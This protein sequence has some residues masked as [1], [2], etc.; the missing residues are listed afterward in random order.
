MNGEDIENATPEYLIAK[1]NEC[2]E[3]ADKE[4]TNLHGGHERRLL[5]HL[6]A[7]FF[8]ATAA[9]KCSETSAEED[10]RR[11]HRRFLTELGLEILVVLLIGGEIALSLYFGIRGIREGEQQVEAV[12]A[13]TEMLKSLAANQAESVKIL[14]QEQADRTKRPKLSLYVGNTPLDEASIQL[15]SS[16]YRNQDL[17]VLDLAVKNEGE[18]PLGI[19]RLHAVMP[20]D[21]IFSASQLVT[22][23]EFEQPARPNTSRVTL[24]LPPLPAGQTIRLQVEIYVP[25]GRPTLRIPFTID[26]MELKSV[27]PLG[28]IKL[29]PPK[30]K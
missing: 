11:E 8:L 27:V 19:S 16:S 2:Y 6:E 26:A 5:Y 30:P 9:R 15:K 20:A 3:K 13:E 7:Q 4:N 24:Q 10:R 29:L 28:S 18:A 25:K 14:Q 22:I 17:A 23:P 21:V 1:A 12:K